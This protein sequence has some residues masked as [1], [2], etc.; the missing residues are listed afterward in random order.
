MS[1]AFYNY[2][3]DIYEDT[4]VKHGSRYIHPALKLSSGI[5]L[6]I[7]K[8]KDIKKGRSNDTLCRGVSIY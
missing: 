7:Y 8:N 3:I 2:M 1:D 6:M 5:W 4:D